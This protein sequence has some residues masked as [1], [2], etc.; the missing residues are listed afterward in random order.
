MEFFGDNFLRP[1]FWDVAFDVIIKNNVNSKNWVNIGQISILG[2][3]WN[4]NRSVFRTG[5]TSSRVNSSYIIIFDRFW[6]RALNETRD[7]KSF[8]LFYHIQIKQ[9]EIT[10]VIS[11]FAN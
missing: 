7:S 6:L 2:E 8:K 9:D 5:N 11:G 10:S 4:E 1:V 3:N